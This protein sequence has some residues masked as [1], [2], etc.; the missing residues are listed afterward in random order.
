MRIM[1]TAHRILGGTLTAIVACQCLAADRDDWKYVAADTFTQAPLRSIGLS[2]QAPDNLVIDV[3]FRGRRQR[4]ARIRYGSPDSTRVSVVV[5]GIGRGEI[6]LYVDGNRNRIIEEKDL[7]AGTGRNRQ[8]E[9]PLET[10]RLAEAS[11]RSRSVRFRLGNG[12]RVLGFGTIG[13]VEGRTALGGRTVRVRRVDGD[14]N[15]AFADSRDRLWIDLDGDESWDPFT[16]QFP[17]LPVLQ[18]G[19]QRI[20]IRGDALGAVLELDAITDVG[21]V[22]LKLDSLKRDAEV[23]SLDVMLVGADGSAYSL[24]SSAKPVTVS[25]GRYAVGTVHVSLTDAIDGRIWSFVFSR[26]AHPCREAW[27]E[28]SK[29][30]T[31]RIDPIG[32]LR[33]VLDLERGGE[34]VAP[35][36]RIQVQPRLLTQGGLL[37]NSGR[38]ART[39]DSDTDAGNTAELTLRMPDRRVVATAQSGFA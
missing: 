39:I 31:A 28:V 29:D 27:F 15:G 38:C 14:A 9:L 20:A 4:Y 26:T 7:V 1:K 12:G 37:I 35:G 8:C 19:E 2:E 5:D 30:Q 6:D 3:D 23:I 33:F 36:E 24:Q 13:F 21:D 17:F 11:Y 16:E 10:I 18:V 25:V 34:A 22:R 32:K